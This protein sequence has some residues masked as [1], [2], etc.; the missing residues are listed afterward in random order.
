MTQIALDSV[1]KSY[2]AETALD[3]VSLSF[4][5][6]VT[7]AVVGRS[8]GGKSTLLQSINGLVRPDRGGVRV[9][10]EP[11]DYERLPTLRRRI[12]YAVQG[13]GLFP[14]LTVYGNIALLARLEGWPSQRIRDRADELMCLVELPLDFAGRYPHELSGGEQQRVGLCRA[15]VLDP[16]LF[17]LDEPFGAL[18]PITRSEIQTE[19]VRL[20]DAAARTIVLVTHDVREAVKLATRLVILDAGRVLQHGPTSE[21]VMHPV[22]DTVRGLLASQ[23]EGERGADA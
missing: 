12:G 22:D 19:F 16:P 9:F 10:G 15:M 21:V 20:Q 13:T 2:G 8:G 4:E 18:D 23:L 6:G 5:D 3:G 1:S 11:I 7:T 14:H 17:L